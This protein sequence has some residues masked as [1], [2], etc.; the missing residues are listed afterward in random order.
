MNKERLQITIETLEDIKEDCCCSYHD[1]EDCPYGIY[2]KLG[3]YACG[4][5]IIFKDLKEK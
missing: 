3:C 2:N 1:C 4:I 5:S